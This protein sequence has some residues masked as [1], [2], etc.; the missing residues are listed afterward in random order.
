MSG[1]HKPVTRETLLSIGEE[2][3]SRL[4]KPD[5]IGGV[6]ASAVVNYATHKLCDHFG[7]ESSHTKEP[8]TVD[9]DY[10]IVDEKIT[11]PKQ[12]NI[13]CNPIL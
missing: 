13:K 2:V 3:V 5:S 8:D 12:L 9:I 4:V 10:E 11:R 1:S 7:I 6:L